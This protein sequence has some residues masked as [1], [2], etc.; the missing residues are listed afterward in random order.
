VIRLYE[1]GI[2]L[3][4]RGAHADGAK[5][6]LDRWVYRMAERGYELDTL[7]GRGP[8]TLRRYA[9]R[10]RQRTRSGGIA[11]LTARTYFARIPTCLSFAVREGRP[12]RRDVF[13]AR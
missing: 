3:L 5:P 1:Y 9:T 8:E 7:E 4:F 10:L 6:E 13:P 12:D 11:A 2:F